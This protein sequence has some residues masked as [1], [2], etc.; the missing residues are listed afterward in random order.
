MIGE[1]NSKGGLQEKTSENSDRY[2]Q[3]T[4]CSV[5]MVKDEI[6]TA[7]EKNAIV[8]GNSRPLHA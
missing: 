1:R 7:K 5:P 2:T 3:T 6:K 4:R 8:S